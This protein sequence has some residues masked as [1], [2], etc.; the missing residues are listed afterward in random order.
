MDTAQDQ[1]FTASV[2]CDVSSP[3]HLSRPPCCE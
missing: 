2:S 1:R 3:S